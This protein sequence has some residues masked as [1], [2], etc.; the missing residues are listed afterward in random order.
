MNPFGSKMLN[1]LFCNGQISNSN[2]LLKNKIDSEFLILISK[3]NQPFKIERKKEYLKQSIR[4]WMEH[5][6]MTILCS[7]SLIT[8]WN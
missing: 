4:R 6:H 1:T 8:F 3:L 7:Y 5:W 2:L